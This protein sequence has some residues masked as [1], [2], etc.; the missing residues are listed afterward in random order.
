MSPPFF[1][2]SSGRSGTTLLSSILNTSNQVTIL[3]E[4]DFIARAFPFYGEKCS[5]TTDDYFKLIKLFQKTSV[6][7]GWKLDQERLIETFNIQ[8]PKSFAEIN[9]MICKA[10]LKKIGEPESQWGIKMPNLIFSLHR[11][12]KIFT[13]AKILH[14]V[15]DRR[16][17]ILSY[18]RV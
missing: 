10:Y 6:M 14:L 12:F 17:E 3:P 9:L 7:D 4:S 1:I 8:K 13:D 18:K 5:F 15:R 16:Y 11:V 2:V